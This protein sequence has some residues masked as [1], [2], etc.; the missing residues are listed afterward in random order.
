MRNDHERPPVR[1]G[2]LQFSQ[3]TLEELLQVQSGQFR[4]VV[5]VN[6]EIFVLAHEMA[7]YADLL[8]TTTNTIDGRVVQWLV[9]LANK[10]VPVR[11]AGADFIGDLCRF[12]EDAGDSVFLLGASEYANR[13]A[14]ERL[15][16]QHPRLRLA[17]YSPPI[18]D[19]IDDA[20][21]NAAIL[22][23]VADFAPRHLV[24]CFGPPKQELWIAA[25]K[26]P[27]ARS[28]VRFAA[29]LG[30]TIDFVAGE[31]KRAPRLAQIVG[32]EWFFRFLVAPRARFRRTLSMF[33]LPYHAWRGAR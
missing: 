32:L 15:R 30:G 8:A 26:E 13:L 3:R 21:W 25:N 2:R 10:T 27:L 18:T 28:G 22:E 6:A 17:G 4:H 5:T 20:Q 12:A 23:R 16:G 7:C 19:R 29:G 33:R 24:V 1:L 31:V 9:A 14:C 11:L